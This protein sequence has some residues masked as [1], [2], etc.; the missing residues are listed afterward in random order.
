MG[1]AA[2][3][4]EPKMKFGLFMM[5]L[6][7][8]RRSYADSYDRDVDLLVH[9]DRVG[10]SEAWV[11]EHV[12]EVWETVPV[13]ELLIAQAIPRTENIVLAT[14]VTLLPLHNPIDTAH[15][16]AMIDHM[17][18]GRFYWGIGTRS[19]PTDLELYGLDP[20]EVRERSAEILEIVL[21]LWAAEDGRFAYEGKYFQIRA[22]EKPLELGRRLY[23]KPYQKPHPPIGMPAATAT[24]DSPR[25]AGER[26]YIPISGSDMFA[27]DLRIHWEK[28][29]Q[30]AG[31]SGKTADRREWRIA[32]DVYVGATPKTARE[33]ARVVLGRPFEEHQWI[34]RKDGNALGAVKIDPSM[35]DEAV[36]VGYMMDNMWIVGDPEECAEKI[37][38]L[39]QDVG[40]FGTLL[41]ITQDPD[42][43]SL[44]QNA[45]R[46]LTEEV[47]PLVADLLGQVGSG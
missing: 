29:E 33:E 42:D 39:Y 15:R 13:P 34:N 44:V 4:E 37:R 26:G 7:P 24:S 16:I 14:G 43:H 47:G 10:F 28:V 32:R 25:V 21:G 3:R 5:P 19:I 8:P 1:T 40:G 46:R 30:G 20:E 12:T 18:R 9:A 36:D 2:R 6:H 45:L 23:F 38:Q 31:S 35:P 22:P 41:T 11:G 17:A 27:G